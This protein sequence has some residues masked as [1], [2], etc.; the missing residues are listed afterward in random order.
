[1]LLLFHISGQQLDGVHCRDE[2]LRFHRAPRLAARQKVGWHVDALFVLGNEVEFESQQLE[3][4]ESL[5]F[6]QCDLLQGPMVGEEDKFDP[7]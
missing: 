6:G 7:F 3:V 2:L 1:V 5:A 4:G